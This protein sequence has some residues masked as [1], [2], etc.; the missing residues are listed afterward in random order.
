MDISGL[1]KKLFT[2]NFVF[3]T[4]YFEQSKVSWIQVNLFYHDNS[5]KYWVL[6]IENC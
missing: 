3:Q 6:L 4:G 2:T 5:E 1:V